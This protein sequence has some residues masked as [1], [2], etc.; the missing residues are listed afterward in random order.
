LY[1]LSVSDRFTYNGP[2]DF[3]NT[4]YF[5]LRFR[6]RY[7]NQKHT[8]SFAQYQWDAKIGIRRRLVLGE[9]FRYNFWHLRK[10]EMTF[11]TGLMFEN[12]QWNY[13]AVDTSKIPKDKSDIITNVLKSNNYIKWEGNISASSSARLA[14]FYQSLF[15][16]FFQPRIAI[17]FNLNVE[18]TKHLALGVNFSGLYD[19]KPI[20]PI[21]NF[22]YSLSNSLVVKL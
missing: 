5:H 6:E 2:Q 9:N 8:E 15:T 16:S 22:Y 4:G 18:A 12:E 19:S 3:L 20:V 1:I 13:T 17:Q 10:W 7:K 21:P 11:G 14:F